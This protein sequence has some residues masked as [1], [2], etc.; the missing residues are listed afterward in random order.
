MQWPDFDAAARRFQARGFAAQCLAASVW[1]YRHGAQPRAL[2]LLL[3]AGVHGDETAPIEMLARRLPGWA[4]AVPPSLELVVALGNLDAITAGRRHLRHDMNRMFGP[5]LPPSLASAWGAEGERAAVLAQALCSVLQPADG[6]PTVHLDLHTTIRPSLKPTFAIVPADDEREPLLHW[7]AQAG[8]HA[9][10]LSPGLHP[11]LSAFTR[12]LGAAACTV[13]LGRVGRFG[14][15]DDALLQRFESTLDALV[16]SGGAE[17]PAAAPDAAPATA[18]YRVTRELTRRSEA[19]ELLVPD[20][21][22]NFQPL[23]PGQLVARDR[24]DLVHARQDG[25]C[26]LFPNRHVALGLRA[27]LLVAPVAPAVA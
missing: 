24:L 19:F 23:A 21:A 27:G 14:S 18:L 9:L 5:D 16:L 15:N 8:L 20:D 25:E 22:P 6:V 7:L 2:R 26:V 12:R 3:T 10:V 4:A 11:T 1:R 13:E 17:W